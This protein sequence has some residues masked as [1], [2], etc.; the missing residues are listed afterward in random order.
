MAFDD[1][2]QSCIYSNSLTCLEGKYHNL[3]LERLKEF[4]SQAWEKKEKKIEK[5]T[6]FL[7]LFAKVFNKACA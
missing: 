4:F 7:Q 1:D 6:I 3:K 5:E 2:E